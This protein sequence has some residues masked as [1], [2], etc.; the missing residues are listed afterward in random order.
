M[1]SLQTRLSTGLVVSL[2]LLFVVQGLIVGASIRHLT[3]NY[4]ASRLQHDTDNLLASLTLDGEGAPLLDPERIDPIYRRPF[5]GHYYRITA[6]ERSLRSRSLWDQ[7]LSL[8]SVPVGSRERFQLSGP[9]GQILLVLNSGFRKQDREISIAV[10]EDLGPIE[11][12]IRRFQLLYGLVSLAVLAILIFTQRRIVAA[13]LSP[14]QKAGE[15][16]AALER[17]EIRQL[18]EDVPEE[19]RPLIRE[20][21]RLLDSLSRRLKR[22]RSAMGNL[23]HALKAPL[24]LLFQLADREG[25]RDRPDL[26]DELVEQAGAV[27][28]LIDRE[29]KR[30]RLAG[31]GSPGMASFTREDV[32]HLIEAVR[33]IHQEKPLRI[34][35]SLPPRNVIPGD[36]EDMLELFGNLLDNAAQ[37][38]R[39]R[40]VLRVEER[41]D[42][43]I[44]LED[45]GPGC[46]PEEIQR[47]SRRVRV[48]E[49]AA[50]HGLGLA[51]VKDIVEQYSGEIGFGRSET[52]GGFQVWIKLPK[53]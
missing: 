51:I 32:E 12:D 25:M 50:G 34:D 3:E 43:L 9:G 39:Q 14:L 17:G 53:N 31:S 26:R 22:S 1:R 15:D 36:R 38:A 33:K 46:T 47:L 7:D 24:T 8:P 52:L 13:G 37:W 5:S 21:N 18:R 27:R 2:V 40:V 49:S 29:L 45:D 44:T 35:S 48:D 30:A 11:D 42:I 16:V 10:S 23:A 28:R 19:V 20:I 4:V 41:G 6:G